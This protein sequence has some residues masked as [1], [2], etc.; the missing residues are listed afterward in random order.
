MPKVPVK[1]RT[2]RTQTKP[3]KPKDP[4]TSHLY[5]DDNPTTTINGTGFKDEAAALRTLE[6]INQRSL[7]YQFQTVNTLYHR[8]KHHP[9]MKKTKADGSAGTAEMREAMEV[10][11]EWVDETYPSQ[12]EGLGAGGFKPLLSKGCVERFLER[13]EGSKDVGE[14]A[15]AFA[16]VYAA[17]SKGKRLGNVLLE[18]SKPTEPDWERK[19]YDALDGLV[20]AGKEDGGDAWGLSELWMDDKSLTPQHLQLVAWAW[21]PIKEAKLP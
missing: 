16:K 14:D 9:S 7:P 2:K 6:L 21:S 15:R 1:S 19:R 12:R 3:A 20:P 17:L 13:I 8:A 10:F 18:D 4:K 5:T 11:R